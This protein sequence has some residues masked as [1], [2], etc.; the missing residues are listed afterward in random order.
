MAIGT[1]VK[2][3]AGDD[4]GHPDAAAA[5]H[6]PGQRHLDQQPKR[7]SAAARMEKGTGD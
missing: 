6:H 1:A 5:G 7:G 2:R 3:F 4:H